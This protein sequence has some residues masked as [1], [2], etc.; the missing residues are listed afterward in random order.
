VNIFKETKL[1]PASLYPL[2]FMI[3]EGLSPWR[4]ARQ[5]SGL[6]NCHGFNFREFLLVENMDISL[7]NYFVHI[8]G[9]IDTKSYKI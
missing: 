5:K 7:Q 8:G 3:K 6:P 2:E 4:L 9:P 1:Q